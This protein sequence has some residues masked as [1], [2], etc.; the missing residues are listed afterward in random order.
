MI[1]KILKVLGIVLFVIFLI[2]VAL[3]AIYY[4][5]MK[6][7]Y[8]G[9]EVIRPDSSL[10]IYLG[11]GGNSVVFNSD[12]AILVIDTKYGKG[13]ERLYSNVKTMAAGKPVIV[14]NTH[15]DLDH[16]GGNPLYKNAEIISG[17]VDENYW[18]LANGSKG[19]PSVWVTDTF[20]LRLGDETV[21]LISMGQAHTWNDIV[22]YFHNRGLLMTGD[23]VFNGINTFFDTKK[24]SNGAKS[25]EALKR[26]NN[27]LG[28]EQV[29]PGHGKTGGREL[30]T[31]MLSYLEDMSLAAENPKMEKEMKKKYKKLASMPGMTSAGIVIDYFR[32]HP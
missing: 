21:T 3:V 8:F 2:A 20:N 1:R 31:H 15:S 7:L 14:V 27:M 13:A 25:I 19:I 30:I 6:K 17:K 24:G 28:I 23:L 29:V 18:K 10:T 16:T 32:K 26:L 12:S 9:N 22:V 4:P 11:G 5:T